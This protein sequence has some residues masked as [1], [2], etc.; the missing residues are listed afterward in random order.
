MPVK[1]EMSRGFF[2]SYFMTYISFVITLKDI[3]SKTENYIETKFLSQLFNDTQYFKNVSEDKVVI[4][5]HGI[6]MSRK[7]FVST[8]K[9]YGKIKNFAIANNIRIKVNVFNVP[10]ILIDFFLVK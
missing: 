6:P 1:F 8:E 3:F 9:K 2:Q 5:K 7:H 10:R 4:Q